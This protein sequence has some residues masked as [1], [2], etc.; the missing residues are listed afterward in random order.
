MPA[1][2]IHTDIRAAFRTLLQT[3]G[4]LPQVA[5]EGRNFAPT[6]GTPFLSETVQP[7][8]SIVRA[9]GIGGTI[10]HTVNLTATLHYPAAAGTLT[11]ETMAGAI[12]EAL[13]PGVSLTYGTSSAMIQRVER[14]PVQQ[15]PDWISVAVVATAVAYSSN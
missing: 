14:N 4:G 2:S 7:I 3:V 12:M 15:S 5:W 10:A 9:V 6:R 11:I 13:R 1:T 8:S